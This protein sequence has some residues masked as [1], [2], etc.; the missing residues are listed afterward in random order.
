MDVA[1]IAFVDNLSD[2]FGLLDTDAVSYATGSAKSTAMTKSELCDMAGGAHEYTDN[3]DGT[4]TASACQMCASVEKTEAHSYIHSDSGDFKCVCGVEIH[5][6]Y[7]TYYEGKPKIHFSGVNGPHT[8]GNVTYYQNTP[9][10]QNGSVW[11]WK[12]LIDRV[13]GYSLTA[14]QPALQN[15]RYV[16]FRI[17]TNAIASREDKAIELRIAGGSVKITGIES[18][19]WVTYIVD[20]ESIET[21]RKD[22][23]GKYPLIT[24]IIL[25]FMGHPNNT[26]HLDIDYFIAN[27]NL[28]ELLALAGDDV[29]QL[30]ANG[31]TTTINQ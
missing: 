17:R 15:C 27:D 11:D 6:D 2:V 26:D 8:E 31:T 7:Y 1:Y 12:C 20:L 10:G 18:D 28:E 25:A 9:S 23:D 4:H 21:Y 5:I 24:S 16:A 14:D 19:G 13:S 29:V 30:Y 22:A 3:G